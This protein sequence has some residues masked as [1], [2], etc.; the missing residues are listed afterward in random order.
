MTRQRR[1]TSIETATWGRAV[2]LAFRFS[3]VYLGVFALATQIA[4]SLLPLLS[5]RGFGPLWPMRDITFWISERIFG[6]VPLANSIDPKGSGETAVYWIQALWIFALAVIAAIAWSVL[7]RKRQNYITL[8]KWFRVFVRLGLAAQMLEYGMTKIIPNQFAA[9]SLNI[10]VTPVGD[11]SL[12]SLLWTSI[13]AAPGYQIFTG[14]AELLAGILLLSPRTTLLGALLCLA[15]L[16]Q[17]ASLNMA[18]DIGLKLTTFHLILLTLFLLVPDLRRLADF[19]IFNRA[20]EAAKPEASRVAVIAQILFGVYLVGSFAYINV[21]YWYAEGGGRPRSALYGI[22]DVEELSIDGQ[23][24]PSALNDYDRR[25]R[26][27]I[28]ELPDQMVF[29]RTDDS[30]ARYGV[31]IDEAGRKLALTKG[32][33]T[34]WKSQFVFERRGPDM[35]ILNGEMDGHVIEAQLRLVEFDT[36]RLLNSEFRWIRPES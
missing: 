36:L 13:G 21:G 22:W 27:V 34:T 8:H 6:I 23:V 28:F 33:S 10:L 9:P 26:R 31:S 16:F 1:D 4:G 11:L 15:D 30:L 35:L 29:Q 17:V 3:F 12:N 24:R 14:F 5:F 18:Y 19:F 7:D 25:W 20:T 32:N 2:L